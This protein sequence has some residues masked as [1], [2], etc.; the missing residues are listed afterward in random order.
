MVFGLWLVD[1]LIYYQCHLVDNDGWW[2]YSILDCSGRLRQIIHPILIDNYF[3]VFY[4]FWA[5]G[6]FIHSFFIRAKG[7]DSLVITIWIIWQFIIWIIHSILFH[8]FSIR[9][10][11]VCVLWLAL[12]RNLLLWSG[13]S[14]FRHYF[15][16][17]SFRLHFPICFLYR[18]I[19]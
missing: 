5:M 3:L 9:L 16:F 7:G 11:V 10:Y 12:L 6:I 8:F 13:L 15:L 14:W 1:R 18:L 17:F 19:P 2:M 4:S